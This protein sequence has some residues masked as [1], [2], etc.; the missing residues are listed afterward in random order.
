[1]VKDHCLHSLTREDCRGSTNCLVFQ[2]NVLE[3]VNVNHK[4]VLR[5]YS[6]SLKVNTFKNVCLKNDPTFDNG[7][8]KMSAKSN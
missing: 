8:Q 2:I 6:S 5:P 4:L 3:Y 1:M 7:L